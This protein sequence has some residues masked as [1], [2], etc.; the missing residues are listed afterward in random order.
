MEYRLIPTIHKLKFLASEFSDP[1]VILK[2]IAKN[3]IYDYIEVQQELKLSIT[4]TYLIPSAVS[5]WNK[6]R[7]ELLDKERVN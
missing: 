1:A 3:E 2:G 6:I 7:F 4:N 5:K